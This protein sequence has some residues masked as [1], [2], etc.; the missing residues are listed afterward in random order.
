MSTT[1]RE[2][3]SRPSPLHGG[4]P[5]VAGHVHADALDRLAGRKFTRYFF[6]AALTECLHFAYGVF[7]LLPVCVD[8]NH[9]WN[10][11]EQ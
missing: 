9:A 5:S 4:T 2:A 10:K 1:L 6:E 11:N 3:A 7:G 8:K